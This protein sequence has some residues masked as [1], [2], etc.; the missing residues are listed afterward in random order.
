M[1]RIIR[2]ILIAY[3]ITLIWQVLEEMV[4]GEIQPRVV[5]DIIWFLY[6]PFIYMAVK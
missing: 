3:G 2:T 6:L 5:D 4:Y 1:I